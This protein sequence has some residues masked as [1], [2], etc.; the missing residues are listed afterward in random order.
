MRQRNDAPKRPLD[1]MAM[2]VAAHQKRR[3]ARH[4][5]ARHIRL[6][7]EAVARPFPIL[8]IHAQWEGAFCAPAQTAQTD[9]QVA[10][11]AAERHVVHARVTALM[12]ALQ[13]RDRADDVRFEITF[14]ALLDDGPAQGTPAAQEPPYGTA[15]PPRMG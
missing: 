4:E 14:R 2:R 11:R 15:A 10:Q 6:Q 1:A 8:E 3:C 7:Q 9:T 12:H 13:E 5:G